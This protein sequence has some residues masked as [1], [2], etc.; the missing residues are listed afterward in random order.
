MSKTYEAT[1]TMTNYVTAYGYCDTCGAES[2]NCRYFAMSDA[3]MPVIVDTEGPCDC[4]DHADRVLV[5]EG[6]KWYKNPDND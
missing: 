2:F 6:E 5:I 4:D 3:S 1:M